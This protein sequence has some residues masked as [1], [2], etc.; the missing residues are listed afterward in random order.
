MKKTKTAFQHINTFF[1]YFFVG[2]EL[3]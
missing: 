2:V 3:W 1:Y